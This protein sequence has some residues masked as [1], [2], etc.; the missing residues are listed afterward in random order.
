MTFEEFV[1]LSKAELQRQEDDRI[2]ADRKAAIR[3]ST[4]EYKELGRKWSK[5]QAL[6]E[7]GVGHTELAGSDDRMYPR[8]K[9][10]VV[11]CCPTCEEVL[12]W[13]TVNTRTLYKKH[14]IRVIVDQLLSKDMWP[15]KLP[16][17][18]LRQGPPTIPPQRVKFTHAQME[19]LK[20]KQC[21]TCYPPK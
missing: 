21:R 12:W 10:L 1:A 17:R 5:E 9:T 14:G 2:E 19:C 11:P 4:D 20:P 15:P 7:L 13:K 6:R 18:L 16:S 8:D 3:A